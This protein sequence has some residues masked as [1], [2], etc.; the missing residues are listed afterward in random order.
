MNGEQD[1]AISALQSC[2]MHSMRMQRRP[3]TQVQGPV[4][5]WYIDG[6]IY[7]TIGS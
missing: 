1:I 5:V 6:P 3:H 4:Y 7:S 2:I